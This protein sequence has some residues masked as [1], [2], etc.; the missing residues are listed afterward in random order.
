MAKQRNPPGEPMMLGDI[1]QLGVQRLVATCLNDACRHQGLIDIPMSA[2][3]G[4]ADIWNCG[5]N[6]G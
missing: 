6:V 1:R 4:K 3:G 5:G 2:F